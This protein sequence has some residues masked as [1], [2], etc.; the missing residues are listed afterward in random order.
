MLYEVITGD[1]VVEIL[2]GSGAYYMEI[3]APYLRE[4]GRYIAANR[5]ESAPPRR[6]RAGDDHHAQHGVARNNFV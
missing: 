6:V 1:T 4:R 3:L 5:D 2:P